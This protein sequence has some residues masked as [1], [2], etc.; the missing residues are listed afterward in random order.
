MLGSNQK[1]TGTQYTGTAALLIAGFIFSPAALVLSNSLD[2][3]SISIAGAVTV[4]CVALA[5]IN[6]RRNSKLTIPSLETPIVR[7]K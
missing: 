4:V 7:P 3:V 5:W 6:W 1:A 2:S